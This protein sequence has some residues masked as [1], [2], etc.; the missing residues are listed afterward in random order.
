LHGGQIERFLINDDDLIYYE[1]PADFRRCLYIPKNLEKEIFRIVH[2]ER[3]HINFYRVYDRIRISL[4]LY[5]LIK[6]LRTYIEHYFEYRIYQ[7]LRHK[8]YGI[9]KSII[10]LSIPFYII[11]SDFMLELPVMAN[12]INTIFIF[13]NKVTK[14][15]KINL[16]RAT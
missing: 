1:N 15:I 2:N 7:T 8:S 12:D 9:L 3:D 16:G 5:K 4:Y 13:I 6:C 10:S 11:Y 14:R